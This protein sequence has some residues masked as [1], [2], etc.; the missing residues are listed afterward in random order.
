[1]SP[2]RPE[3]FLFR[4]W[5][6][7]DQNRLEEGLDDAMR[8]R[9]LIKAEDHHLGGYGEEI[10]QLLHSRR[11]KFSEAKKVLDDSLALKG[12]TIPEE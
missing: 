7:M 1:M 10:L 8:A 9:D 4:A 6:R 11:E 3:D 2:R 5:L 12:L